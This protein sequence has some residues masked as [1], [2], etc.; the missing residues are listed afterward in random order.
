MILLQGMGGNNL[1]IGAFYL[2]TMFQIIVTP[3]DPSPDAYIGGNPL[4]NPTDQLQNVTI[5][6]NLKGKTYSKRYTVK[7]DTASVAVKCIKML[8]IIQ[9]AVSVTIS[10]IS[11]LKT[12]IIGKILK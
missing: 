3:V 7:K 11:L 8:N 4:V 1:V 9:Q 6:V 10:N 12:S 2:F 5:V